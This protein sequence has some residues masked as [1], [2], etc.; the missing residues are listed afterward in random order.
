MPC[1]WLEHPISIWQAAQGLTRARDQC[2]Q[3]QNLK[4]PKY[5]ENS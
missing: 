1:K 4:D 5:R 3:N 2:G